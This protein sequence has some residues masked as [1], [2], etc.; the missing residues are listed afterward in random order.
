MANEETPNYAALHTIELARQATEKMHINNT[1]ALMF[2][3]EQAPAF[4]IMLVTQ[5]GNIELKSQG[6]NTQVSVEVN[7][8]DFFG[9]VHISHINMFAECLVAMIIRC[10]KSVA[11]VAGLP[12][13]GAEPPTL[14]EGLRQRN[15]KRWLLDKIETEYEFQLLEQ[16]GKFTR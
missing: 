14:D 10:T 16:S 15:A 11:G 5:R 4:N 7:V 9:V 12:K 2:D 8:A 13:I 3:D 1:M 6:K